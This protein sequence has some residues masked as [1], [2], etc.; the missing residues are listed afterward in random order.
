MLRLSLSY[1]K[2]KGT[3][4]STIKNLNDLKLLHLHGNKLTGNGDHFDQ[5]NKLESFITDCGSTDI[6]KKLVECRSCSECCNK[7]GGCIKL[8]DTWPGDSLK[9]FKS[10]YRITPF[11]TIIFIMMA[12]F[13]FLFFVT[14]GIRISKVTLPTTNYPIDEFQKNSMYRFFLGFNIYGIFFAL[15]TTL[16]QITTT[17]IFFAAGDMTSITNDWAYAVK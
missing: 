2:F 5:E 1:N 8:A 6:A 7:D 16:I 14:L 13:A 9:S 4:P 15:L 3:I 10:D 17:A 12:S 11:L